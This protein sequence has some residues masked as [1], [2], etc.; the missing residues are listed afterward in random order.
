MNM[1]AFE[2]AI[3]LEVL[4][5]DDRDELSRAIGKLLREAYEKKIVPSFIDFNLTTDN[6]MALTLYA[7]RRFAL[8]A[9]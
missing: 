5:R 9:V 7:Y 1:A 2:D 8:N 4:S 3:R 6:E